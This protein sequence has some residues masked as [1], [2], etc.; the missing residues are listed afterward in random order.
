M[1]HFVRDAS[2]HHQL[3]TSF[4]GGSV[5]IVSAAKVTFP[6]VQIACS[7][8]L[9]DFGFARSWPGGQHALF[10]QQD[11]R[12]VSLE[13]AALNELV[14][15]LV[16]QRPFKAWVLGSSPSELTTPFRPPVCLI[17]G[18]SRLLALAWISRKH[19][20]EYLRRL[21]RSR[22]CAASAMVSHGSNT[23]IEPNRNRNAMELHT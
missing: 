10:E 6:N 2:F 9:P 17:T 12:C 16:E 19:T 21:T 14:A 8:S 18:A 23:N 7:L 11:H 22:N 5:T 15:Q 3:V 1:P 4:Q 20:S 13:L